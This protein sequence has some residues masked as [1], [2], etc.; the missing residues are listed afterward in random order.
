MD[1]LECRHLIHSVGT[2]SW[3][4][5]ATA[6]P[7]P[8]TQNPASRMWGRRSHAKCSGRNASGHLSCCH[9]GVEDVH[10]EVQGVRERRVAL[11]LDQVTAHHQHDGQ[12]LRVVEEGV[13]GG[14]GPGDDGCVHRLRT[15]AAARRTAGKP[16]DAAYR[17]AGT[18][19]RPSTG[20]PSG[21]VPVASTTASSPVWLMANR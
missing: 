9:T 7:S 18:V 20:V 4:S 10:V 13:P 21:R 2:R 17:G 12:V 11:V 8:S 16:G 1:A 5:S 6:S 3:V 19:S 14:G 15:L